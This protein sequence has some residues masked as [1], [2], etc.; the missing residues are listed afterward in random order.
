MEEFLARKYCE[1]MGKLVNSVGRLVKMVRNITI[2][3][4]IK[5]LPFYG[6]TME[7][8]S[9]FFFVS[10]CISPNNTAVSCP[11]KNVWEDRCSIE[12]TQGN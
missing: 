12:I 2:K 8:N 9:N 4:T 6:R 11:F 7:R 3:T 10:Y 1:L 5:K